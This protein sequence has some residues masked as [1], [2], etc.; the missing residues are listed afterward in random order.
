LKGEDD[1]MGNDGKMDAHVEGVRD[2]GGMMANWIQMFEGM[3][4]VGM[5]AKGT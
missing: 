3:M 2:L 5:M 1:D 4:D